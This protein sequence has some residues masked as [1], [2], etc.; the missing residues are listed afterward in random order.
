[1]VIIYINFVDLSPKL[2]TKL[3]DHM[4]FGSGEEYF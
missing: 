4:T 1:M 2:Q 3:Q